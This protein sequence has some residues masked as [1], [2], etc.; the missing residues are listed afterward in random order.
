MGFGVERSNNLY[1]KR[2]LADLADH[3]SLGYCVVF[4]PLV[5]LVTP[6]AT[7]LPLVLPL[8]CVWDIFLFIKTLTASLPFQPPPTSIVVVLSVGVT[9]R[10]I[11]ALPYDPSPRTVGIRSSVPE[12]FG[13]FLC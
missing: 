12:L 6:R 1:D 11:P 5:P 4:K 3:S 7:G 13:F 2:L 10:D 8:S 9:F